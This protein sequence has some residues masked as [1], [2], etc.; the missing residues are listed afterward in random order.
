VRIGTHDYIRHGT[1]TLFAA[2]N[3]LDGKIF[4]QTA[5][6][7]THQEWLN[8]LKHL[9]KQTPVGLTLHLIIMDEHV[10]RFFRD[11]GERLDAHR[12]ARQAAHPELTLTGM[13]NVLEK[14]RAGEPL[15]D[16]EKKIH[17]DLDAA[18]YEVYGW[19]DLKRSAGIPPAPSLP[20]SSP[21]AAAGISGL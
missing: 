13:Y 14:L 9:E 21:L 4:R 16:K 15:N 12:K 6:S 19:E 10:E 1:I 18:V 7:H 5:E 17:D 2:L 3:Y 8:F 11:L 20:A